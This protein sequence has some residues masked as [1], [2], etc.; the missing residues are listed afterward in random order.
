MD[1]LSRLWRR[2]L[3]AWAVAVAVGGGLTLWLQESGGPHEPYSWQLN[4]PDG[5]TPTPS[6]SQ[7]DQ[8]AAND[9]PT[10]TASPY[11]DPH[12]IFV[13]LKDG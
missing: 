1:G 13:C 8:D 5:E 4:K 12:T 11:D 7:D 2:V 10:P 3:V 9:C 6:P